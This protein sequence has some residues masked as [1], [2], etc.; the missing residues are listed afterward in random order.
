MTQQFSFVEIGDICHI[1]STVHKEKANNAI[2][3]ESTVNG[4]LLYLS[5]YTW[6]IGKAWNSILAC[7]I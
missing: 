1:W 4:L 7:K 5:V 2:A 3:T 6:T